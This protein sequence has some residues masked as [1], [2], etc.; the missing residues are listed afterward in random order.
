MSDTTVWPTPLSRT[1]RVKLNA[2]ATMNPAP[3]ESI[4][5]FQTIWAVSH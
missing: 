5:S 2:V 3:V 1:D 4:V